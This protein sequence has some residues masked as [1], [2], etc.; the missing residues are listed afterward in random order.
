M[1][2]GRLPFRI[3]RSALN[4]LWEFMRPQRLW[5]SNSLNPGP[6]VAFVAIAREESGPFPGDA[7]QKAAKVEG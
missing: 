7:Y 6:W 1:T 4:V 5:T 2:K 3:S